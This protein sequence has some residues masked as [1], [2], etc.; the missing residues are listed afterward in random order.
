M[1]QV[2]YDGLPAQKRAHTAF[3]GKIEGI[4][5][6][7]IAKKPQ[8]YMQSLM[9]FLLGWLINHILNSDQKIPKES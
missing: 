1:E 9:E 8:D 2:G 6:E 7:E 5:R 4:D 3:I